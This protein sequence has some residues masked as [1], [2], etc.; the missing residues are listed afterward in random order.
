VTSN[1]FGVT[2]SSVLLANTSIISK[3]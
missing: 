3:N 2:Y 1:P